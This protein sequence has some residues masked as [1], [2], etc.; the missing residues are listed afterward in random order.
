[1]TCELT[2]AYQEPN[3]NIKNNPTRPHRDEMARLQF[4]P[5]DALMLAAFV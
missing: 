2:A 1:M 3:A 5:S 4:A